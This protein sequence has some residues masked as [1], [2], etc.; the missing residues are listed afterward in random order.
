MTN[1]ESCSENPPNISERPPGQN[2]PPTPMLV[3]FLIRIRGKCCPFFVGEFFRRLSLLFRLLAIFQSSICLKPFWAEG[4]WH[5]ALDPGLGFVSG[6][7]LPEKCLLF[8]PKTLRSKVLSFLA[9]HFQSSTFRRA[10]VRRVLWRE[11]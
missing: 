6:D 5:R 10:C 3:E 7:F 4:F 1:S 2:P 11:L 8:P 9:L